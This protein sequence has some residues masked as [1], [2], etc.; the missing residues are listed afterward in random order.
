[1]QV[2]KALGMKTIALTGKDGSKLSDYADVCI[3]VPA[4]QTPNIQEMHITVYHSLCTMLEEE[5]FEK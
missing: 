4:V 2:A 1:M 3:S 5:F